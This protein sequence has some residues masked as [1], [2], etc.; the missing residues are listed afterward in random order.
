MRPTQKLG[1]LAV[2]GRPLV[3]CVV[4]AAITYS[5]YCQVLDFEFVNYDDDDYVSDNPAV[6]KGLSQ[7]N[8]IWAFTTS[9][10]SNW[11]PITWLS[12]M[13]D[14]SLFGMDPGLHHLMNLLFHIANT[15]LM[16]FVYR[17][18]TGKIWQSAFVAALF[19]LHP[20]H[21]QSVAWV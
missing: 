11:H 8:L 21:V 2:F 4:L 10:A 7:E 16:F 6:Q 5:I 15:L 18:M 12:H 3:I 1:K 14:V 17:I 19:A 13:A 9:H 20:L